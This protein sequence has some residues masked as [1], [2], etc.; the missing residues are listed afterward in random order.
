MTVLLLSCHAL[1]SAPSPLAG[2]GWG[3]GYDAHLAFSKG[4]PLPLACADASA[5]D[6]PRKGGGERVWR[7]MRGHLSPARGAG[8]SGA[9]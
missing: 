8:K 4:T 2:E 1:R 5:S 6:L 3:G 7:A 9:R